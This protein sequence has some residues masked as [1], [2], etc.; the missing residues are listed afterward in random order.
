MGCTILCDATRST[1]PEKDMICDARGFTKPKVM[2]LRYG[3]IDHCFCDA[4]GADLVA[5]QR[6]ASTD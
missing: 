4:H 3:P 2:A 6:S 5:A 1:K